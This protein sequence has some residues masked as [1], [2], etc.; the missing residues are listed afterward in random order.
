M[1][2][3]EEN[4]TGCIYDRR[5]GQSK[6]YDE[7]TDG[8]QR[9]SSNGTGTKDD[10][11]LT[12][13]C[14]FD[15][16]NNITIKI[17]MDGEDEG[18]LYAVTTDDTGYGIVLKS[19]DGGKDMKFLQADTDL[20]DLTDDRA[21]GLIGKW[22]DNSGNEYKLK[23]DGKLVIKSSSGETKGTYCVAENADGTL[24]LNLVISGGT[25]E[26]VYTLSDDG[27]TVELCSPGT[28]TVHKWTKA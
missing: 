2:R 20:L 10:T 14:G 25:L 23:K 8:R 11:G 21:K 5:G 15:E 3:Y 7:R 16:D 12:F 22:T 13:E 27:S 28:D 18:K 9:G 24:R 26:Y 17:T 6:Q 19:L 4:R 1:R